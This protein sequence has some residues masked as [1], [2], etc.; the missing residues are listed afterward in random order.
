M[1]REK[2]RM[3]EVKTMDCIMVKKMMRS[4]TLFRLLILTGRLRFIGSCKKMKKKKR[5]GK[6][7]R[8]ILWNN[9]END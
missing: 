9:V 7:L 1:D 2:P 5:E 8:T 3:L 4:E 6:I